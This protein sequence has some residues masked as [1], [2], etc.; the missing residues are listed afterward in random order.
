MIP[1]SNLPAILFRQIREAEERADRVY[2]AVIGIV[3][4]NKD[5]EGLARVK[6]KYPCLGDTDTSWWAPVCALGAGDER[7][8]FF[9]PEIDDEVVVMFEHGDISRPV[10]IGALWNGKDAP[11]ETNDS[12]NERKVIVSR[13]GS[14]IT[15]DDAE[16]TVTL[17]DG[18]GQGKITISKENTIT[19]ESATGD[20]CFLAPGGGINV[21]AKEFSLD[22]KM[23]FHLDAK[24]GMKLGGDAKVTLK[25][26]GPLK[27]AGA[28]AHF[29]PGGVGSAT[30]ASASC[31]DAPDPV[32]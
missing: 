7:G 28:V 16:G 6:V 15:F 19:I 10:V 8:W 31:E 1:P 18:G 14:K 30:A 12:A 21:V 20:I 24:A 25:S 22:A 11:P 2:E 27:V 9:L 32:E 29:M 5:T 3:T 13:E 23:N 26:S 4:D 17:E